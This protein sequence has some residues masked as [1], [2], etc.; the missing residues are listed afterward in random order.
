MTLKQQLLMEIAETVEE[1]KAAERNAASIV[2]DAI[3]R[4]RSIAH[5]QSNSYWHKHSGNLPPP[6]RI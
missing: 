2:A 1:F 6:P 3:R 5:W 4:L